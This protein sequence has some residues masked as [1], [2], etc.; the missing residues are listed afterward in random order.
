VGSLYAA[1]RRGQI[2][3][4]AVRALLLEQPR[5]P[6]PPVF[7][8]D[9]SVWPRRDAETGPERAFHSS[10]PCQRTGS[11]IVRG[12]AY[13][14]VAQLSPARDRWTAPV[15][16]R[17]V[18]PTEPA[19]DVAVEL[20]RALVARSPLAAPAEGP[21]LVVFDAWYDAAHFAVALADTPAALLIRLRR[22]RCFCADLASEPGPNRP[23]ASL[24]AQ[25]RSV[26]SWPSAVRRGLARPPRRP[27][28]PQRRL[29]RNNNNSSTTGGYRPCLGAEPHGGRAVGKGVMAARCA[30]RHPN[31]ARVIP[32]PREDFAMN[33]TRFPL[34]AA[35]WA[36]ARAAALAALLAALL[37]APTPTPAFACGSDPCPPPPPPTSCAGVVLPLPSNESKATLCHFTGSDGNP[38]V[39]NEVGASA[40]NSHT[41]HHG[42]CFRFF[43]GET[44]CVP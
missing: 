28:R 7:A 5:F 19:T 32:E 11:V 43:S 3:A 38:F 30:R 22:N 36:A 29:H 10:S 8:V 23:P 44:V 2:D 31:H 12:W 13:Q 33:R 1:L 20:V 18:R 14:W 42:D 21:P 16:V 40:V 6:G 25:A 9:V 41:T 35:A 34:P 15:Y 39:I 27:P 24:E 17:R 26:A 4:D 37:A